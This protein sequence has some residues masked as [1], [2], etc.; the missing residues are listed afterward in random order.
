[1][2]GILGALL[3][4][5]AFFTCRI[6]GPPFAT[7]QQV[8]PPEAV[9]G[10]V[11]AIASETDAQQAINSSTGISIDSQLDGMPDMVDAIYLEA[12]VQDHANQVYAPAGVGLVM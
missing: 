8:H 7:G 11:H 10:P 6:A 5:A 3:F 4:L 12:L 2:V 1:M 9:G